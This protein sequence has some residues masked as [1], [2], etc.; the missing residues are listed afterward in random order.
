MVARAR[1]SFPACSDPEL[2]LCII[3]NKR[4]LINK[5]MN[6]AKAPD[7]AVRACAT[8]EIQGTTCAPQDMPL[9]PKIELIG[10]S[11]GEGQ[12]V[13]RHPGR[14]LYAPAGSAPFC[15]AH[16]ARVRRRGD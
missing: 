7:N 11:M 1:K 4:I 12:E 9:W 16:E 3:H 8:D 13:R 5:R 2:V 14:G 6:E 10:C 15:A